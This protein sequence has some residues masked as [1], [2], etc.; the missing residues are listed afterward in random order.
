[1]VLTGV[2][3]LLTYQ[4]NLEC[5]HCFVWG[6]PWQTG[7]ITIRSIRELMNQAKE[8]GTVDWFYFEGGE[9]FL[10]Y[11]ILLKSIQEAA[12]MGFKVGLVTN[13]YWA[14]EP[15]DAIEWLRP[16]KDL[17][18]DLSISSDLYHWSEKLSQLARNASDAAGELGIPSGVIS[19]AQA[20]SM[21]A[22][23]PVGKLPP[24]ESVVMYRGRAANKLSGEARKHP[25][26]QFTSCPYENLRDPG[27]VHVD[28]YGYVHICQGISLG[29][30]NEKKLDDIISDYRPDDHPIVG[31]ILKNGPAALVDRYDLNT[32]EDY[33][34][35]CHLCSEAC[36]ALRGQFTDILV[37]DQM[38]GVMEE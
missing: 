15:E 17:I 16:M 25:W 3:L 26:K 6:S 32:R 4:C 37:P 33:A 31:P 36:R 2:H 24:G 8:L 23:S 22:L 11:A 38:F 18:Q 14:T 1:M 35:A 29:N 34:D 28:P 20:D 12:S 9:P 19:I 30:V 10:Y 7:T 21:D 13:G 5:D 27:R